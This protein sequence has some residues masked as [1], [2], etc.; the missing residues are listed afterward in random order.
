MESEPIYPEH[1]PLPEAIK[2]MKEGLYFEGK[3]MGD[4]SYFKIG[5][6]MFKI[7]LENNRAIFGDV[8]IISLKSME[9]WTN[10]KVKTIEENDNED[11]V[12]ENYEIQ[13]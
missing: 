8:V 4:K 5:K 3:Y 1:V 7:S 6:N 11:N 12:E 13:N 9:E 2:K 10:K